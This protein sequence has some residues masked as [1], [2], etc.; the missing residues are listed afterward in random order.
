METKKI[1]PRTISR[2]LTALMIS[3]PSNRMKSYG[4][5]EHS[6]LQKK[7]PHRIPLYGGPTISFFLYSEIEYTLYSM[8]IGQF[9]VSSENS[10]TMI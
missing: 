5:S 3:P 4:R 7:P 2:M 10:A 6:W 8:H 9:W 1:A